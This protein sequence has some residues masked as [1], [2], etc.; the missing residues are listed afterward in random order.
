LS[1][2]LAVGHRISLEK[3]RLRSMATMFT[4]DTLRSFDS[5]GVLSASGE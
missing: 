4:P 5:S 3:L 2:V 1:S